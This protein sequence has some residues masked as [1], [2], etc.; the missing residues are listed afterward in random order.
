MDGRFKNMV[1]RV[2]RSK[3]CDMYCFVRLWSM[4]KITVV[5]TNTLTIL[6][7][8]QSYILKIRGLKYV[9]AKFI[10]R[11]E[12]KNLFCKVWIWEV[13]IND[14]VEVIKKILYWVISCGMSNEIIS[15]NNENFSFWSTKWKIHYWV[16]HFK[17]SYNSK[18]RMVYNFLNFLDLYERVHK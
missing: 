7:F 2:S 1:H 18:H 16:L 15:S 12:R 3:V 4:V 14:I 9:L 10:V 17:L 6:F 13:K 11:S 8:W 5:K